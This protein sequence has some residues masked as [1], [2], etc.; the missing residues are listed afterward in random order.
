MASR[1]IRHD[2]EL[3]SGETTF[4]REY[5]PLHARSSD[6]PTVFLLHGL[7]STARLDWGPAFRPLA[8]HFRV[9]SLDHRGHGRGPRADRFCLRRCADDVAEVADAL[10]IERFIAAGWSM[11]GPIACLTWQRHRRR[12]DGLVLCATGRHFVP[13][14]AAR[15]ARL[16]LPAAVGLARVLPDA[17]RNQLI[18]QT[19]T[20]VPSDERRRR[21]VQREYAGHDPACVL[22]AFRELTRYA[23]HD[24]V[25]EIDVP[26]ASIVTRQDRL[27][28]ASKQLRLAAAIPDTAV[29]EIDGDHSACVT[30]TDVFVPALVEACLN[31]SARSRAGRVSRR[32]MRRVDDT[33]RR[34]ER[35][36]RARAV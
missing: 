32:R 8:E 13:K 6:V 34:G 28:P 27:V 14:V 31:V 36:E 33:K 4:V 17:A 3:S 25:R 11:G 21:R 7:G 24:W 23:A 16:A 2:L 9:V 22:D 10:G 19:L 20:R 18:H 1:K 15:A 35:V 5:A 29:F 30:Q 12:L 26:S